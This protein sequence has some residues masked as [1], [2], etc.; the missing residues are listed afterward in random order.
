MGKNGYEKCKEIMETLSKEFETE[1]PR[2]NVIKLIA[3]TIGSDQR[4]I[5][6]YL[7]NLELFG[8]LKANGNIMKIKK[9]S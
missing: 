1:V 9:V 3:K 8:M 7:K 2:T 4:T 6:S 5:E